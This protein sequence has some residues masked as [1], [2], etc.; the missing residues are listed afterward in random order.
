MIHLFQRWGDKVTMA[1]LAQ[2]VNVIA[3]I[4]TSQKGYYLQPTFFP[5]ELYRRESGDRVV[6]CKAE[7]PSF[8][9]E[10]NG[11]VPYLDICAT[12]DER[13]RLSIGVVNRHRE[14]PLR[15]DFALSGMSPRAGG[16]V[17]TINGPSV[18]AMNSFAQPKL[19]DVSS[20]DFGGFGG[21]F[22]FEFPAHSISLLQMG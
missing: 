16:K 4:M 20:R 19:V 1:N 13:S 14:R 12:R 22:S 18:D 15:A 5:L 3:P 21:Q 17:F 8:H 7:G 6:Q 10:Q 2:M 11:D 9:S